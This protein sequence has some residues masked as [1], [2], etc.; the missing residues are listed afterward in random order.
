MS[1]EISRSYSYHISAYE[2][3]LVYYH[4]YEFVVR[5]PPQYTLYTRKGVCRLYLIVAPKKLTDRALVYSVGITRVVVS[6]SIRCGV[7]TAW[8]YDEFEVKFRNT[9]S[10]RQKGTKRWPL[11]ASGLVQSC[12]SPQFS[13]NHTIILTAEWIANRGI[14]TAKLVADTKQLIVL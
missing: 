4:A 14:M 12:I 1:V 13:R 8:W 11:D 9:T 7:S 5:P 10:L 3:R 2:H 6:F